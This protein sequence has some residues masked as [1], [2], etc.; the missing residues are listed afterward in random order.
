MRRIVS[1]GYQVRDFV[2]ERSARVRSGEPLDLA[3][4]IDRLRVVIALLESVG[5]VQEADWRLPGDAVGS[6]GQA[7]DR[8]RVDLPFL[9]MARIAL[10]QQVHEVEASVLSS[11]VA[12]ITTLVVEM[13]CYIHAYET[14]MGC[15]ILSSKRRRRRSIKPRFTPKSISKAQLQAD[16]E[17]FLAEAKARLASARDDVGRAQRRIAYLQDEAGTEEAK[18]LPPPVS[19]HGASSASLVSKA[20]G[21]VGDL[22]VGGKAGGKGRGPR[23]RET[24]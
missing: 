11:Y 13:A 16:P 15:V 22:F 14:A 8:L 2:D 1:V 10:M 18:F 23:G 20:T 24:K 3:V 9:L 7:I 19:L 17:G 21:A 4:E 5:L 12:D 6:R